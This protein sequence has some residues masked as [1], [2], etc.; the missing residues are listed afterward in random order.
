MATE[1]FASRG[2]DSFKNTQYTASEMGGKNQHLTLWRNFS[3]GRL[4]RRGASL[5]TAIGK[6]K[7]SGENQ[8]LDPLSD[9]LAQHPLS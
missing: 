3:E 4:E 7:I 6:Q 5:Q 8:R 9:I 1:T 2:S